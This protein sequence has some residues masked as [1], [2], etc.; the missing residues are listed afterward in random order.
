MSR[1][2]VD[3]EL[4]HLHKNKK[5]EKKNREAFGETESTSTTT[6]TAAA[7]AAETPPSSS[8]SS[9]KPKNTKPFGFRRFKGH[10]HDREAAA[11]RAKTELYISSGEADADIRA[12]KAA[13]REAGLAGASPIER[14]LT[15]ASELRKRIGRSAP[16]TGKQGT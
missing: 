4:N 15:Q 9:S 3:F 8:T 13:R 11:K 12:H 16:V 7:A 6:A 2:N 10:K 14:L 5:N 1:S